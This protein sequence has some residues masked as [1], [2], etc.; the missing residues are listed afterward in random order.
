MSLEKDVRKIRKTL[1]RI[2][3]AITQ[4]CPCVEAD[5]IV[6]FVATGDRTVY[7]GEEYDYEDDSS[8]DYTPVFP[9][10]TIERFPYGQA[11]VLGVF[12]SWLQSSIN[13]ETHSGHLT[14]AATLAR[15]LERLEH[16]TGMGDYDL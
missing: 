5:D 13:L 2:E 11:P 4:S 15:A 12:R 1:E 9:Y 6:D 14:E 7:V 8:E 16:L 10:D 3:F